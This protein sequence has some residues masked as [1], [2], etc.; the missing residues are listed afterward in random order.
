MRWAMGLE[1]AGQDYYGWQRQREVPSVQACVERGLTEILG[2]QVA[3]VCAGR[4]DAGV[5]ATNQVVHFDTNV[6]RPAKAFTM[7][8]NHHL[9]ADMAVKWAVPVNDNFSARFSA[10]HRRYR[11]LIYNYPARPGIGQAAVT[12]VHYALDHQAMHEAAQVLVG[13]HDFSSFRAALCQSKTPFRCVTE[14]SVERLGHY[15]LVDIKANA[16]LHHMVRNIVGSLLMVGKGERDRA[17]FSKLLECRD[18]T[19]AA[20]TAKPN[21]LYLVDVSYPPVWQ[22]PKGALGPLWLPDDRAVQR[23]EKR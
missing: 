5:H 7:G 2:H 3:L 15:V 19:Q 8:L 21:G 20:A 13:E 22:L 11:Y 10:T 4:T 9:P 1:Y 6:T 18:R 17:W 14:V 16:F 12:H 23:S